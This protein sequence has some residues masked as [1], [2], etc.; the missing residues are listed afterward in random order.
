MPLHRCVIRFAGG[1][2]CRAAVPREW[3][4]TC[5]G[6]I[7]REPSDVGGDGL[8]P[9]IEPQRMAIRGEGG[10]R[11]AHLV[12]DARA[13]DFQMRVGDGRLGAQHVRERFWISSLDK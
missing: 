9:R 10:R 4:R 2:N 6:N 3:L 7:H 8:E 5:L 11:R 13:Q 1:G 12:K